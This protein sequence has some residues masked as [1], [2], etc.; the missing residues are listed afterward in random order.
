[1]GSEITSA[2]VIPGR[3]DSIEPGIY[4]SARNCGPMDSG[5]ALRAPRNDGVTVFAETPLILALATSA[6]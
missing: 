4:F 6:R 5:L 3:C 2:I 1:M